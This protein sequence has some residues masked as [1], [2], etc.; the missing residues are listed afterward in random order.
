MRTF[1]LL[2]YIH[3]VGRTG[4]AGSSGT[5]ISFVTDDSTDMY[6]DLRVILQRSSKSII[7]KEVLQHEASKGRQKEGDRNIT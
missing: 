1:I 2:D 6:F 4:R 3:R 5:A 7:P